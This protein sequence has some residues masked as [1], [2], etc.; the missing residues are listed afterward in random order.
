MVSMISSPDTILENKNREKYPGFRLTKEKGSPRQGNA[1][2]G[3]SR[4]QG[5]A[6]QG[7]V[8]QGKAGAGQGKTRPAQGK[9]GS[10]DLSVVK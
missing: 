6:S 7:R 1:E 8:S 2:A 9:T 3:R 10:E 4:D 5:R